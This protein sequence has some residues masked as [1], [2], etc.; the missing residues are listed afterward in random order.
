MGRTPCE[1][2][3]AETDQFHTGFSKLSTQGEG[4]K[5]PVHTVDTYKFGTPGFIKIDAE[6]MELDILAGALR[7]LSEARPFVV[8]ENFLDF[9]NP[10]DTYATI[11]FLR[12]NSYRVFVPALHFSPGGQR[13][14]ATYGNYSEVIARH[15]GP[16]LAVA[17]F[18]PGLRFLL[19]PHVNLLA[20]HTS[21]VDE[22][23]Q[24]G[25]LNLGTL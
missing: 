21:R 11:H 16:Q 12:Q 7:Q 10:A 18:D 20:V 5:I 23:W 8:L 1:M 3:V 15:G 6:G 2:V 13:I 14:L 25:I 22:L 9:V 19:A 24:T 17:E 4:A